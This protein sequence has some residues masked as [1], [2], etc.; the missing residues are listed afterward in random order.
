G[1]DVGQGVDDAAGAEGMAHDDGQAGAVDGQHVGAGGLDFEARVAGVGGEVPFQAGP[2]DLL[3]YRGAV[4]DGGGAEQLE[5][6]GA[7]VGGVGAVPD[8]AAAGADPG[9][10]IFGLVGAEDGAA[11]DEDGAGSRVDGAVAAD[12][13][14]LVA[15]AAE[16][17]VGDGERAR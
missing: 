5:V 15:G 1:V 11:D 4:V 12:D 13:A 7:P 17:V 8:E 3:F 6:G 14:D 10:E 9:G 16:V 2:G